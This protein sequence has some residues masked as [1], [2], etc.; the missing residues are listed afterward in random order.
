MTRCDYCSCRNSWDCEDEFYRV[1]PDAMCDNFKLDY[2]RLTTKQQETIQR[3]LI[4]ESE[5]V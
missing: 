4:A 2:D 3:I 5:E 1:S